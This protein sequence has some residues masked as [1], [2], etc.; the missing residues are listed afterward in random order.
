L[1][2]DSDHGSLLQ[3]RFILTITTFASSFIHS[4]IV[5]S[6]IG[7]GRPPRILAGMAHD[8][9]RSGCTHTFLNE[10]GRVPLQPADAPLG[11]HQGDPT[12][13]VGIH[14]LEPRQPAH[15]P[16]RGFPER[17]PARRACV[18]RSIPGGT[19]PAHPDHISL[20]SLTSVQLGCVPACLRAKGSTNRPPVSSVGWHARRRASAGHSPTA[21]SI[22]LPSPSSR[23]CP[24][25]CR[26]S[27]T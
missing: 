21:W 12:P 2:P 27:S 11:R 6:V 23:H 9:F 24:R 5:W 18:P 4:P 25:P 10:C 26:V 19:Q 3:S 8:S 22:T 17:S 1:L 7:S 20:Q 13:S 15:L 16:V 14:C